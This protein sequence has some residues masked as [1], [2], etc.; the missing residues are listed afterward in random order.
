MK[1]KIFLFDLDGTLIDSSQGITSSVAYALNK[2]GIPH[3]GI[4]SLKHFIG[5]PLKEQFMNC[6][7]LS[8]DDGCEMVSLYRE[9]Y[10]IKGIFECELYSGIREL[11]TRLKSECAIVALA[12]SKPEKYAKMI[13]EHFGI[14][15]MFD[16]VAGAKMDNTRTCK[17][18]VI[19]YALDSISEGYNKSAVVM[20]GD[21]L[22]DVVGAKSCGVDCVFVTYGFGDTEKGREAGPITCVDTVS[23]LEEYIF[24]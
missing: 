21:H 11:L 15:E 14:I 20:I 13:L 5:P 16:V 17:A 6:Y 10:S 3:N 7:G 4:D 22:A 19:T 12:T 18:D 8:P 24:N 1:Y 2:K 9:Y 23:E